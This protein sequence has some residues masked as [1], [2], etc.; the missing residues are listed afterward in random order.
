M[1]TIA[2]RFTRGVSHPNNIATDTMASGRHERDVAVRRRERAGVRGVRIRA[3]DQAR[4]QRKLLE[5]QDDADRRE[6]ALDDGNGHEARQL[7]RAQQAE[8]DLQR[9]RDQHGGEERGKAAERR[10]RRHDDHDEARRRAAHAQ[11]RA[12]QKRDDE[13]ADDA[14]HEACKR[15]D[16][17]CRRD[18]EIKRQ[19]DQKHDDARDDVAAQDR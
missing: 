19:R 14:R 15:L 17:G 11:M 18:A 10:D 4:A 7:S 1:R 2:K 13:A 9:A 12:A 8:A 16:A 5:D 6:H 3:A